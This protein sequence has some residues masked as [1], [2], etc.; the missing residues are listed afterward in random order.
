MPPICALGAQI[1]SVRAA[2]RGIAPAWLAP[3]QVLTQVLF[4]QRGHVRPRFAHMRQLWRELI[5]RNVVQ[6]YLAMSKAVYLS[7]TDT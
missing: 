1:G 5:D 2:A 3:R 6:F 4:E 7:H